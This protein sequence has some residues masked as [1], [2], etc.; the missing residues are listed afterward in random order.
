MKLVCL[1]SKC[2]LEGKILEGSKGQKCRHCGN[3]LE[4]AHLSDSNLDIRGDRIEP[5]PAQDSSKVCIYHALSAALYKPNTGKSW[6]DVIADTV[7]LRKKYPI[8]FDEDAWTPALPEYYGFK[9]KGVDVKYDQVLPTCLEIHTKPL[10]RGATGRTEFFVVGKAPKEGDSGHAFYIQYD[11]IGKTTSYKVIDN[12]AKETTDKIESRKH[13]DKKFD[14]YSRIDR[15][16]VA[17]STKDFEEKHS[18]IS[19]GNCKELE[20]LITAKK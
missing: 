17:N 9:R 4:E 13:S 19:D 16:A 11:T 10:T 5:D 20:R 3:P 8:A 1:S 12:E 2:P 15:D 7:L 6:K 14:L 18:L